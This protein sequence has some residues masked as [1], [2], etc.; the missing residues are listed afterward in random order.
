MDEMSSTEFRR[1]YASLTRPTIVTVNGHTIGRWMPG[2]PAVDAVDVG[3]APETRPV[4]L[5]PVDAG[6]R[7]RSR[8]F[9][10][11]PKDR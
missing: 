7:F 10:P 1:R 8:P 2:A 5:R 3:G 11:V 9:T 6:S 4:G